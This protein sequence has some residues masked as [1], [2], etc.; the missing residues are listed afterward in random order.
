[1]EWYTGST[2][3][4]RKSET[5]LEAVEE[6]KPDIIFI[7]EANLFQPNREFDLEIE[8]YTMVRPKTWDKLGRN[9][10]P[11]RNVIKHSPSLAT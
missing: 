10:I 2:H 7:T 3:W 4:I 11:A 1:M 6:H 5:I 9:L 8:G